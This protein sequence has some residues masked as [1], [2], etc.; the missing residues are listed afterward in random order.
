MKH[1]FHQFQKHSSGLLL[2]STSLVTAGMCGPSG[3][4]R[5]TACS[6]S[7]AIKQPAAGRR[8]RD[9]IIFLG[10]GSSTGC[11]KPLCTMLF[12]PKYDDKSFAKSDK[13]FEEMRERFRGKCDVSNR[14]IVGNPLYNKDYRNNPSLL[15]C[16]YDES[17]GRT[18]H[19]IID[20]GKT[21]RE[22][23]LR[24][25]PK[26]GIN[27]LDAIILTQYVQCA[28]ANNDLRKLTDIILGTF[29]FETVSILTRQLVWM[30]FG[31][32]NESFPPM[33]TRNPGPSP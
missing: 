10:T 8:E 31:D 12:N 13:G 32:F 20:V 25:F 9:R 30:M 7:E 24:W 21:F 28:L 19:I 16:H 14:A 17:E 18:K 15:I 6:S 26:H 27:S 4:T 3:E 33:S 5:T 29:A 22:T 2:L 1:F 11:P 23:S